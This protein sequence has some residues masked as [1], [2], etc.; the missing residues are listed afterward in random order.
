MVC[1]PAV[2]PGSEQLADAIPDVTTGVT[3]AQII[4]VAPD[5]FTT[6][7]GAPLSVKFTVLESMVPE[8]TVK[9]A[10]KV[11]G[12]FTVEVYVLVEISVDDDLS[13]MLSVAALSVSMKVLLVLLLFEKFGSLA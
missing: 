4:T 9:V 10:A 8:G 7:T 12:L 11:T 5:G 2:S 13:R 3:L 6:A 1:V